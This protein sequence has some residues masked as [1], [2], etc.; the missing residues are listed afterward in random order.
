MKTPAEY[1]VIRGE[2]ISLHQAVMKVCT[3]LRKTFDDLKSKYRTAA[4][5]IHHVRH[6]AELEEEISQ[7]LAATPINEQ[8][9]SKKRAELDDINAIMESLYPGILD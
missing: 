2:L 1:V 9:I 4:A 3:D 5:K 8:T 6:I 7:L